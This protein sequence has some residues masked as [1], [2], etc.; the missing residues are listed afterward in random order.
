[1][2]CFV[3]EGDSGEHCWQFFRDGSRVLAQTDDGSLS[4][5]VTLADQPLACP[6][7]DVGV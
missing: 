5:E 2:I 3:Y 1:M 7:P 4:T 6:G